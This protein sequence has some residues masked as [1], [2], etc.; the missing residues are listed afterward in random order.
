MNRPEFSDN[1]DKRYEQFTKEVCEERRHF[2]SDET[3]TFLEDLYAYIESGSDNM[4]S[5]EKGFPLYRAR[6][7]VFDVI[8]NTYISTPYTNENMKP[9]SNIR[10]EGRFNSYNTNVLYLAFS[11]EIAISEARS[12]TLAPVSVG[13]FELSREVKVIDLTKSVGASH[14]FFRSKEDDALATLGSILSRPLDN[15]HNRGRS[16]IPI[17]IISEYFHFEKGVDGIIYNSQFQGSESNVKDHKIDPKHQDKNICLYDLSSAE[18]KSV[19]VW[20]IEQRIN[21]VRRNH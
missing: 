12:D 5:F 8:K 2:F 10:S 7:H 21:K 20:K 18:C 9:V 4:F 17:Q 16:Y 14:Y 11:P 15:Q 3:L 13:E 1:F 6:S 19:D